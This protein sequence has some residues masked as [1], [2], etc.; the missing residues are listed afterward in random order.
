[1]ILAIKNYKF[2]IEKIHIHLLK[3]IVN[4][5]VKKFLKIAHLKKYKEK[6]LSKI[7]LINSIN[8][9]QKIMVKLLNKKFHSLLIHH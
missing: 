2:K 4:I 7:S 6:K 1:M 8:L 9:I 3:I 5:K